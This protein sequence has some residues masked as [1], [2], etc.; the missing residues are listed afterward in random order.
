MKRI[1]LDLHWQFRTQKWGPSRP[2]NLPHDYMIEGHRDPLWGGETGFFPGGDGYYEKELPSPAAWQGKTLLL[3]VDG[4]YMNAAVSLNGDLLAVHPYGYTAFQVDLTKV[5]RFDVTNKLLITTANSLQNCRWYSGSGLYRR[6]SLLLGGEQYIHPWDL[7]VTTPV[8]DAEHALVHVKAE[9]TNRASI[10]KAAMLSLSLHDGEDCVAKGE[11]PSALLPEN[12]VCVRHS[13]EVK[14]PKLWDTEHPH[15]YTLHWAL[16]VDGEETDAGEV[17]VGIRVIEIDAKNGFRLNGRKMKLR[18]GCIHH[19]NGC[20]GACAYPDA[21]RRKIRI[22]KDC[23]YNAIR[24]A[25]N[26]PSAELLDACD[27]M[28]MLVLDESF[29]TWRIRKNPLDYH[30][31]FDDWWQRDLESMV[32]RDRN[33]PCIYAWSVGNEIQELLGLA[34]GAEVTRMLADAV[35]ALDSRPVSASAN[36]YPAPEPGVEPTP[37]EPAGELYKNGKR[38]IGVPPK[39]D[40]WDRQT[41]SSIQS[42][43]LFGANY[44]YGRYPYDAKKHPDRVLHCTESHPFFTYD[45]WQAVLENDN[46]IGDFIWTAFDNMGEAG[47]G[48]SVYSNEENPMDFL[49]TWPWLTCWQGDCDLSGRRRPQSYFRKV[50]WG[51]DEGIHLFSLHPQ[52]TGKKLHGYGWHWEDL[53]PDWSWGEEWIGQPVKLVAYADCDEVVFSVNGEE[54]TVPVKELTAEVIL[55][56]QPGEVKAW[57]VR[58]GERCAM[59]T[60]STV[61]GPFHLELTSEQSAIAADGMS[62]AY[63]DIALKDCHGRDVLGE[64]CTVTVEVEGAAEFAGLGSGNPCTT[65][66]Y[67]HSRQ[68]FDGHALLCLRSGIQSGKVSIRVSSD[69]FGEAMCSL[70]ILA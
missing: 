18:G 32:R 58:G 14:S 36:E 38:M 23:G 1:P 67:T 5:M 39:N 57:A 55:P 35:R 34:H 27:E 62:I 13:L 33:H 43:D 64:D 51:L 7:H 56:Y 22:L 12:K 52:H 20:L 2:V 70:D 11:Y 41:L 30:I 46:C 31:Y 66:N 48:R 40:V 44:M 45:Y 49:G 17:R 6:V 42:L 16:T 29:D 60:L 37:Y 19:D 50:L 59:D 47:A 8:A 15:L 10:Q 21:E 69:R 53:K 25:H 9:I 65:E 24:T 26:P 28:G 4:A 54:H 63:I 61:E 3:D 68:L